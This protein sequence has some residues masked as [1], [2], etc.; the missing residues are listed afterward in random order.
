MRSVE[1]DFSADRLFLSS[2]RKKTQGVKSINPRRDSQLDECAEK[3]GINSLSLYVAAT[4][5]HNEE[6]N[7]KRLKEKQGMNNSLVK[8]SKMGKKFST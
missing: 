3:R 4:Y 8:L 2:N 7:T 1:N 5:E 6:N